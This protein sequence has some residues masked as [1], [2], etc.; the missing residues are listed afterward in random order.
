MS[1]RRPWWLCTASPGVLSCRPGKVAAPFALTIAV[2]ELPCRLPER[3]RFA[4]ASRGPVSAD[5]GRGR[6]EAVKGSLRGRMM[7]VEAVERSEA[8]LVRP[9]LHV[10]A[11]RALALDAHA[12]QRALAAPPAIGA[13]ESLRLLIRGPSLPP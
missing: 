13:E 7:G 4:M 9:A 10:R 12:A 2:D 11:E 8:L 1:L 6:L 3:A 5:L